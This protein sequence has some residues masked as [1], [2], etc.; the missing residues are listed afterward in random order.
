MLATAPGQLERMAAPWP[1]T[2][3]RKYSTFSEL[4]GRNTLNYP[5][6][7]LTDELISSFEDEIREIMEERKEERSI[8]DGQET[9]R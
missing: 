9:E 5:F 6:N 3:L 1:L 2:L 8:D 7:K 4:S